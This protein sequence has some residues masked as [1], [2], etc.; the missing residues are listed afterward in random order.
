MTRA[1]RRP[2]SLPLS[3]ALGL[4]VVP[5]TAGAAPPS[6]A[7]PEVQKPG[8]APDSAPPEAAEPSPEPSPEP[9]AEAPT[10]QT[11]EGAAEGDVEPDAASD[12]STPADDAARDD[13]GAV[14]PTAPTPDDPTPAD[15]TTSSED[16]IPEDLLVAE[17]A[18]ATPRRPPPAAT[19][20][21][22]S[23]SSDEKVRRHYQA[24]YRPEDNPGLL[25]VSAHGMFLA[26]SGK[27]V[28]GRLGG[29]QAEVGQ[30][31]NRVGYGIGVA[32]YGG[33]T[34]LGKGQYSQSFGMFGGGPTVSLGRTAL[35]RHGYLDLT[36]G[37][38]FF[39]MPATDSR[40]AVRDG[41]QGE[42]YFVPHGPRVRLDL[43]LIGIARRERTLR[44]GMGISIGWQ[45]LI[46]SL[47]GGQHAYSNVLMVGL[48][49]MAQ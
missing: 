10:E 33:D 26:A 20:P 46:S 31:W 6:D 45:G 1:T 23:V 11:K 37:Y 49:Y 22:E 39:Y 13:D 34:L 32:A 42:S 21:T 8:K 30:S 7:G 12:A 44:H 29:I 35:L 16:A 2:L 14:V 18:D 15:P 38:D 48:S 36:A 24:M 43:G 3:L 27:D 9:S 40:F 47:A 4:F 5:A 25:R 28:G 41:V 17:P 19:A